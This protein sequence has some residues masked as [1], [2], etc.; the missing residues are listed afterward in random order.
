M[1]RTVIL[2]PLY[3]EGK[4]IISNASNFFSFPSVFVA[5]HLCSV[6]WLDP[7]HYTEDCFLSVAPSTT[8]RGPG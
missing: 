6:Y 5:I 3:K 7:E 2:L 8:I 1:T 4:K